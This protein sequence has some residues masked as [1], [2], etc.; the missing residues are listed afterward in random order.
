MSAK[1]LPIAGQHAAFAAMRGAI[2]LP[3]VASPR[4]TLRQ[5]RSLGRAMSSSRAGRRRMGRA[6]RHLRVAYPQWTAARRRAV[7]S[8]SFEHLA[9]L[10]AEL[11]LTPRLLNHDRWVR[12]VDFSQADQGLAALLESRPVILITGHC[13]NWEVLGYAL[14]MLGF[15]LAALYRPLDLRPLD[16]WVRRT[17][18]RRGLELID[19]FGA[20]QE[21]P[22]L[23][24][25]GLP[26]AFVADQNGGDRGI[27]VPFFNRLASTYKSIS[28]LAV[29]S[30][31]M[32]VCGQARR[33]RPEELPPER[34]ERAMV[35]SGGFL[36]RGEVEDVFGP[37]EYM[38]QPDPAFYL[39]ARYRRAIEMMIRRQPQDYF[40]MH[41][42]WRSR[43]RHER[44][45]RP[46][47]DDLR[48]RLAA[49][50]WM[51]KDELQRLIEQSERDRRT[52]RQRGVS[53]LP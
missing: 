22:R 3:M 48:E 17:R 24:E 53:R 8:E 41:R 1:D 42:S 30:E 5:A 29:Q 4:W 11:M 47:P 25:R 36:F 40:W 34:R 27:M 6:L 18:G 15:P 52:L 13:G 33:V 20:L 31:A 21:L 45:D 43:P 35:E 49:L 46:F 9:L 12:H 2:S 26:V 32:I 51:T 14:A 10:G 19:K 38:G 7:A 16:D 28:L 23:V 39:T 50:P 37:E 44:L